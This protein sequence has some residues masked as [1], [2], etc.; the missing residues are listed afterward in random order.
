MIVTAGMVA[1]VASTVGQIVTL[2]EQTVATKVSAEIVVKDL[3]EPSARLSVE[4]A[5]AARTLPKM[6]QSASVVA[7]SAAV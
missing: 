7:A 1:A 5:A 6:D 2:V 3:I 4:V